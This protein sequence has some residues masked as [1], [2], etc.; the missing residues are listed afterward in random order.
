MKAYV[1][2]SPVCLRLRSLNNRN[3][4]RQRFIPTVL[5]CLFFYS[6]VFVKINVYNNQKDLPLKVTTLSPLVKEVLKNE[7]SSTTEVSIHFVTTEE[8][9]RLHEEFF[10]DPT[11]TDCISFPMDADD[12]D[13][14]FSSE[15]FHILGEIFVCPA[16]AIQYAKDNGGNPYEETT[17]Y[18]I[19]GLLHLLGYDDIKKKD[20]LIMRQ[21]EQE[22]LQIIRSKDLFIKP[23]VRKCKST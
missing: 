6:Q 14:L 9:C 19:H 10:D 20:R 12:F 23:L 1:Q 18:V 17:L 4:K 21:K 2:E 15:K 3:L 13:D 5:R 22:N 11:T 8:I 16:T 7:G